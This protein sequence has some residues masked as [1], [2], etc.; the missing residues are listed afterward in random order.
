MLHARCVGW[1]NAET[2]ARPRQYTSVSKCVLSKVFSLVFC[3]QN[4][5][6]AWHHI[7]AKQRTV[8]TLSG[9]YLAKLSV[10]VKVNGQKSVETEIVA[11]DCA[12]CNESAPALAR[13]FALVAAA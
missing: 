4:I 6:P 12:R 9:I 8:I 2:L 7:A 11:W 5:A 13:M 3:H 10:R 1:Q